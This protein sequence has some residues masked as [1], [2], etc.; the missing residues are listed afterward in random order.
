MQAALSIDARSWSRQDHRLAV[1]MAIST[2]LLLVIGT[3]EWPA[4]FELPRLIPLELEV[5]LRRPPPPQVREPSKAETEPLPQ[6][7][8]PAVTE[9][10]QAAAAERPAVATPHTG[11]ASQ[12]DSAATQPA[13][14]EAP[15]D[16]YVELERVSAAVTASAAAEPQSMH[17]EFDELRR[18]AALRYGKPRTNKPPPGDWEVEKD[19]YGRTLLRRGNAYTVLDDPSVFNRYAFETFERHMLFFTL[20]FGRKPRPHNLPW[21]EAI[22]ARYAYLREPDELPALKVSAPLD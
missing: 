18:V 8:A 21:V 16:W 6:P 4:L 10:R 15:V 3:I 13:T 5:S 20:P 12:A 14:A 7:A 22:R 9:P 17:P 2:G 1:C 11:T 19:S